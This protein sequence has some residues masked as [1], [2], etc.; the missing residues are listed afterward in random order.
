MDEPRLFG[1]TV[2]TNNWSATSP[3]FSDMLSKMEE[4][5][6]KMR[7]QPNVFVMTKET[8]EQV[9]SAIKK[10]SLERTPYDGPELVNTAA[11]GGIP[12]EDYDTVEQ[13]LDRMMSPRKGE[14]LKL[15]LSE[16]LPVSCLSH[17]WVKEQV[18]V[19]GKRFAIE[20]EG[21]SC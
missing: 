21:E 9:K 20:Y 7:A 19:F 11:I 8:R 16:N 14:R 2:G 4:I 12:I 5:S 17:P 1:T 15:V 10:T 18:E 13:C 3:N 6:A